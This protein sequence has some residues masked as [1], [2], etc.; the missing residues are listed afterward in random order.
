MTDRPPRPLP[1][2]RIDAGRIAPGQ[3]FVAP[4]P[5]L[6]FEVLDDSTSLGLERGAWIIVEPC[7]RYVGDCRYLLLSG[8]VVRLS[9]LWRGNDLQ[10]TRGDGTTETITTGEAKEMVAGLVQRVLRQ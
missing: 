2:F 8:E 7:S 1:D 9:A 5:L 4:E 10:L 3:A 6:A